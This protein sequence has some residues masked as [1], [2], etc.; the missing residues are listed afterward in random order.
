MYSLQSPRIRRQLCW[1]LSVCAIM[2][3]VMVM[4]GGA[5][6][7][8][9]SGL[10]MVDWQ[11]I[12][13][14]IPPIGDTGWQAAFD[15][16][17]QFP[18]YKLTKQGMSIAEFRFIFYMEYIHRILGRLLGLVFIL[19]FVFF[20]FRGGLDGGLKA[21]LL[22]LLLLGGCQGLMGWYMV[23]SGLVDNPYVS[24]YRLTAHL[25][26]A[27]IIFGFMVRLLTRLSMCVRPANKIPTPGKKFSGIAG[28]TVV[29]VLVMIATGGMVAGTRAGFIYN[30]WPKMG[31]EWI[32]DMVLAMDPWWKNFFEN[33]IAIQFLHR[34]FAIAVAGLVILSGY[35]ILRNDSRPLVHFLVIAS[36]AAISV[37]VVLGITT[38]IYKVPVVLGVLHQG[39]ALLV[40]ASVIALQAARG[41]AGSPKGR[42]R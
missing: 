28:L 40:L 17:K 23:Q 15:Q 25:L 19:P 5:V 4:L 10:S 20:L 7:L 41:I 36:F 9:G 8:T 12:M 42:E 1:W 32:P 3:A 16:Y 21:R 18:E 14:V 24:H 39:G 31:V 37:Q 33:A 27:V 30:S 11:P 29:A 22:L 38:L 2:V 6:R 13:G 35:Q 34:W 26:L